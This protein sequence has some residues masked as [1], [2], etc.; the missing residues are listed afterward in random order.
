MSFELAQPWALLLL[1]FP[2]V[3]AAWIAWRGSSLRPV[4]RFPSLAGLASARRNVPAGARLGESAARRRGD[5]AH[6]Q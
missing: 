2:L 5:T 1:G 6:W 4:L 3:A